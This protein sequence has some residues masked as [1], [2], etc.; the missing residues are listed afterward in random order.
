MGPDDADCLGIRV[1]E[2]IKK[3]NKWMSEQ[4]LNELKE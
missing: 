2:E 4:E 3:I 1:P